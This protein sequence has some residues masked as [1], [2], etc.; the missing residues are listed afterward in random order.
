MRHHLPQKVLHSKGGSHKDTVLY[1]LYCG[2]PQTSF[3]GPQRGE[4]L[5]IRF[6]YPKD[7]MYTAPKPQFHICENP[8][9]N[10]SQPPP[11]FPLW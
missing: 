4:G 9:T 1:N 2:T 5:G 7:T 11:F 8:W 6:L 3:P 10:L